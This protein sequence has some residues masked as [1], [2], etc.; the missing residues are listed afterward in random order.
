MRRFLLELVIFVLLGAVAFAVFE[1]QD[2]RHQQE[3]ADEAASQEAL[4]ADLENKAGFW[5]ETLVASEAEAVFR[6]FAAGI[7]PAV[8][9]SREGSVELA[10]VSLLKLRGIDFVHV[11]ASNGEVLYSSDAKMTV[12]DGD[13]QQTAWALSTTELTTRSGPTRGVTEVAAP[14]QGPDGPVAYLWLGYRT[15]RILEET[16]P[17]TLP[18][19]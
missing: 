16:R 4:V 5:A 15:E 14:I 2:R 12:G 17:S 19:P 3:L 11:L 13:E 6:A 9:A 18:V 8:L 7:G 10:A 1:W